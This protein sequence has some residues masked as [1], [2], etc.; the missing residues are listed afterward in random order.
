MYQ[1]EDQ[2]PTLR[3]PELYQEGH[4]LNVAAFNPMTYA[5][6]KG[7]RAALWVQ[8]CPIHCQGCVS[9]DWQDYREAQIVPVDEMVE[10]IL[11]IPGIQGLTLSGGEPMEQASALATLVNHLRLQ[12]DLDVICFSGYSLERLR[13]HPPNPGVPKLIEEIDVLIDGPYL[14]EFNNDCGLRGSTNQTVH[15]LSDRLK[16]YDFINI[17]RSIEVN[18]LEGQVF[19]TGIPSKKISTAI[20]QGIENAMPESEKDGSTTNKLFTTG[21]LREWA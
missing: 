8:G 2:T 3:L 10:R 17:P 7:L 19:F 1:Y 9:P 18:I 21:G 16:D 6:G 5:L 15:Y 12:R 20:E 11:S 14:P 13:N 4:W